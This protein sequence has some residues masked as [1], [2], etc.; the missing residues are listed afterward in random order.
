MSI[1]EQRTYVLK[2]EFGPADYFA[3]YDSG[4]REVQVNALQGFVG[5]F[6]SEVGELNAVISLWRFPS[7]EARQERRATLARDERWQ[8]FLRQVRPMLQRMENRLLVPAAFSP[9]K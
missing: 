9:L 4:A 5:Y 2:P 7:F 3:L 6:A 1:I 8:G